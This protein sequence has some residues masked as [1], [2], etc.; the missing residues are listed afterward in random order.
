MAYRRYPYI[1][2]NYYYTRNLP[3]G[4]NNAPTKLVNDIPMPNEKES[5]RDP[6]VPLKP[7]SKTSSKAS[8]ESSFKIGHDSSNNNIPDTPDNKK[9]DYK[10]PFIKLF[11]DKIQLDD[12]IILGLIFILL[13]EGIKDD[14]LFLILIYI[15]LG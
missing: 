5:I 15:L 1:H 9:R 11:Q 8:S 3:N 7:G 10:S 4:K 14:M 2:R 12:I 13:Y 6:E